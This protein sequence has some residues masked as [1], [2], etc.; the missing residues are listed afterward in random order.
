MVSIVNNVDA[1]QRTKRQ[2]WK[3]FW[4]DKEILALALLASDVNEHLEDFSLVLRIHSLVDFID[5][6]KGN[7]GQML[8]T[9][10]IDSN[11]NG[12][13]AAR[14]NVTIQGLE[15]LIVAIL[16][17]DLNSIVCVISLKVKILK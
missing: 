8:E 1:H 2:V 13:F 4:S 7:A 5:T 11:G 14:L 15:F 6:A 17:A 9:Q 16:N 12:S 3:Q 10:S